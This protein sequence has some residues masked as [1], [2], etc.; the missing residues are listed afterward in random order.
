MSHVVEFVNVSTSGIESSP[1]APA[2]AGL[3]ANQ[4]RYLTEIATEIS[5]W[6]T[7][8]PSKPTT[9]RL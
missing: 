1:V 6:P 9:H 4:A 8:R 7:T 3:R 2:L 5:S